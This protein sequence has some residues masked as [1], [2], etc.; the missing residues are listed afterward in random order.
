[1]FYKYTLYVLNSL[2]ILIWSVSITLVAHE[3]GDLEQRNFSLFAK[4]LPQ[5]VKVN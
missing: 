5:I 2:K 3:I 4:S 1:M